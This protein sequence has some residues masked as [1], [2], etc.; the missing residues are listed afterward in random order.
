MFE[1][2]VRISALDEARIVSEMSLEQTMIPEPAGCTL[3]HYRPFVGLAVRLGKGIACGGSNKSFKEKSVM[4]KSSWFIA[5]P[6]P[7]FSRSQLQPM[8]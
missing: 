1:I 7:C 5:I 3:G 6:L 8:G 4:Q 2:H